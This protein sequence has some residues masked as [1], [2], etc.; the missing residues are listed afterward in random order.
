MFGWMSRPVSGDASFP[1]SQN[2]N[3]GD[4]AQCHRAT[5]SKPRKVDHGHSHNP[6]DATTRLFYRSAST[7]SV[8]GPRLVE[9]EGWEK[10]RGRSA[11]QPAN[12]LP[13][14]LVGWIGVD[15]GRQRADVMSKLLRQEE[16]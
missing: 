10:W 1:A 15:G 2:L 9:G 11:A 8:S 14:L 4:S 16:G 6:R 12:P 3:R 13:H 7:A 5:G